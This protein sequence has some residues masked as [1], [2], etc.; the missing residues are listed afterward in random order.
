VHYLLLVLCV[1]RLSW[2]A[3]V[4][5]GIGAVLGAQVAYIGNRH[6][7]FAHQGSASA[8]WLKFQFTA[9]I[10]ALVGMGVVGLGVSSGW[11]YLI[12]QALATFISLILSF[13]LNKTWTFQ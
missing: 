8:S 4:G 9:L 12:A 10:G 2:P 1:E 13:A 6:L 3:F 11:H 5:S 7:T